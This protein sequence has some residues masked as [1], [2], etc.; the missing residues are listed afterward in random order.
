M[1]RREGKSKGFWTLNP[2]AV[3]REDAGDRVLSSAVTALFAG[4]A[5]LFATM[6]LVTNPPL[7][8]LA[9]VGGLGLVVGGVLGWR[10]QWLWSLLDLWS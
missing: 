10:V 1:G 5:V 8:L 4:V 9:V 2:A 3:K 6:Y 7:I